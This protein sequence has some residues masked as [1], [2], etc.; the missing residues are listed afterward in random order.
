MRG[1]HE[2]QAGFE[3]EAPIRPSLPGERAKLPHVPGPLR[4]PVAGRACLQEVQS[5]GRMA[6]G[7]KRRPRVLARKV[8]DAKY[9]LMPAAAAL[10]ASACTSSPPTPMATVTG[11]EVERYLGEWHQVAAIPAW[12][13]RDCVADTKAHYAQAEDGLLKVLNSCRTADGTVD[14]AEARARFVDGRADG[15]LEVTFVEVL[16]F[17][18][19]P[20]AGNYW[21]VGLDGDYRWSV[22]GEPSRKY[23]WVLARSPSLDAGV[24]RAVRQILEREGYD[25]CALLLTTPQDSGRLCD[26]TE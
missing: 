10:L 24:L 20:A 15:K 2:L 6:G 1:S 8:R 5:N 25:S 3:P 26:A 21:I 16:G 11:F 17:W 18:L 23:A 14:R 9:W 22:V 13:Q 19:W 4:E 12:F 7:L